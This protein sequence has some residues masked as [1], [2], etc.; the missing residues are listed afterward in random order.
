MKESVIGMAK[1]NWKNSKTAWL[2]TAVIFLSAGVAYY[3]MAIFIDYFLGDVIA[4]GNFLYA[5][6]LFLAIFVPAQNFSKLMH[7]GGNRKNFFRSALITYV[8]VAAGASLVSILTHMILDALLT[9]AGMIGS[10]LDLLNGFGF[11]EH[12]S[13][14][15]FFQ[16]TVFLLFVS[17][18][19]HTLTLIQ[20]HWYGW[21]CDGLIIAV[22]CVFTPIEPL[23]GAL[24]WFWNM[25]IFHEYAIV[26]IVFCLVLALAIYAAS[27]VPI[28]SKRI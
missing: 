27:L 28:K 17:C 21:V 9:S 18:A 23:R 11:M 6:P 4:L 20:G 3:I 5:A 8:P 19:A 24:V 25:A 1:V 26:Q 22:I 16:M 12:G 15:A 7:L 10:S 13:V 2:I 14:V